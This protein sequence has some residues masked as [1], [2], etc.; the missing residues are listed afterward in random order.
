MVTQLRQDMALLKAR[1]I[2]NKR[3]AYFIWRKPWM[4][5]ARHTFIDH[6]LSLAGFEN[7][8]GE[9]ERYPVVTLE[10]VA[11]A[12]PSAILLS[13]EPYPFKEKHQTELAIVCPEATIELVDGELFSWYGSRLLKAFDYF[14][15]LRNRI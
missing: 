11:A 6:L 9:Q 14:K 13:S 3:V 8:F 1:P 10:E 12:Q 5:A 2:S 15:E 4:I 7:V